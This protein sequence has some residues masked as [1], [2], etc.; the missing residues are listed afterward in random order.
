M[1]SGLSSEERDQI[2]AVM[3]MAEADQGMS[4]IP[5]IRQEESRPAPMEE[6]TS[7]MLWSKRTYMLNEIFL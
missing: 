1:L 6:I 3:K 2:L 7:S 5:P 4:V